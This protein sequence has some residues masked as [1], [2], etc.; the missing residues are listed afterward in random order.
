[1]ED[2]TRNQ[3]QYVR[4]SYTELN[5]LTG[6]YYNRA[7]F[8][9]TNELLNSSHAGTWALVAV[10][11][12][13]FRIFNKSYGRKTGDKLL[14]H[15]ANCVKAVQD[16]Y[17][18]I[19]GYLGGDNFCVL[20][21]D[22]LDII[23]KLEADILSGFQKYN[24]QVE[25]YPVFGVCSITDATASAAMMYDCA[26]IALSNTTGKYAN[27]ICW[28]DS[29]LEEQ[30]E[31]ELKLLSE[32]Q[33][34]LRNEEFTF[35]AQPQCDI[36][37]GKI[38]GAESLVRWNHKTRGLVSPA[39]FIPVLEKNGLISE[40]DRYVWRHV[41][42][43]LRSWIDKGYHPV[44]ISIN[45][46][47]V[48][49]LS[50]DVL[51]YLKDLLYKYHLPEKLLK[52]EITESA[53]SEN[54]D[55]IIS[56]VNNLRSSGFTV[57]MDD[58]GSG[59]SSL[60]ML[61]HISVDVLKLD[62]RFLEIDDQDKEKGIGIL[63]SVVNMAKMM[64]LP[65]IVEGVETQSQ[66]KFLVELGCRYIQG[67]YYYKP[68]PI[69]QFE[70]LLSD[71]RRLD[72][73][74]LCCKQ[75][76]S[77]HIKELL[78][79]NVFNDN[80]INNMLG[81]TAFYE[82]YEN[83][84]TITRVNEQYCRL[85]GISPDE[86]NDYDTK[87][88][89]HVRD[90]DKAV[91]FSIFEEAYQNPD[92]VAHGNVHYLCAN[93]QVLWIYL[94]VFFLRE[95]NGRKLFFGSLVDMTAIHRQKKEA[96][97]SAQEVNELTEKQ[98]IR[99]EKYY[100]TMPYGYC[101]ARLLLDETE[102]PYDYEFVYMNHEIEK[103][104][105]NNFDRLRNMLSQTFNHDH[106]DLL[107]KGYRAAFLGKTE[108]LY[109][110]SPLSNRYLQLTLYQYEYGY[111]GG[112][113]RDVTHVHIYED[114]LKSI[115]LSY[116]EVY[117]IQLQDNYFRMIY[118]D[119]TSKVER[120][121]YEEAIN[122]HFGTGKIIRSDEQNIR[123]FLSLKNLRHMLAIQDSIEYRYL[124]TA[125]D[126]SKEWCIT[127]FTISE[128]ENGV[129]RTALMTIR[130][131][132]AMLQKEEEQRKENMAKTLANMSDGFF[133]YQADGEEK[134]LYANPK[135]LEIYGCDTMTEFLSMVNYS[136]RGMVHPEDINRIEWEISNQI[137]QSDDNID[138]I[139]YRI[140]RKD[141]SIRWINDC[142]HL[143]NARKDADKPLFYVFISDITDTISEQKKQKLL[144]IN[145]HY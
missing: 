17:G 110:Y 59:Y 124:R 78:D 21:P 28:Y 72:F 112:I 45:V 102:Q 51:S 86:V 125:P 63:E 26:T 105:C 10:D 14:I 115:M 82:I 31:E 33:S 89:S 134:I 34:G 53:Y 91:L 127:N 77:M 73:N 24:N 49:I 144:T 20:M 140:I 44:P 142:G 8:K 74:G 90:D 92:D 132:E 80:M 25:F 143:E 83:Q 118:P 145:K 139:Q 4:Q 104:C 84:I 5:P 42:Q 123:N 93:G 68:L 57:M 71:E 98:H 65:V 120:G 6:L 81:A 37:T 141:G 114:A 52:I 29:G 11:I 126:G 12:E 94:K 76:E 121:N 22:N 3:E 41:C 135:V 99:L 36:S 61:K 27:R 88:G 116:R 54:N 136:F 48:D 23:K 117:F 133:I 7:F 35:F 62:M 67:Y 107:M 1:M 47:R 9:K 30:L 16:L 55:E 130:S 128:R 97:I 131:I 38:V 15:I 100:G 19:A 106:N 101:I 43:W 129:P 56:I 96:L 50:M 79:D 109:A 32:I 85:T 119:E 113:L 70:E 111:V 46:S 87:L 108:D 66:E 75:V 138:F 39:V 122:R 40:L 60:N 95:R 137:E 58:F 64:G 103:L 13:H 18:G 69:A 2:D